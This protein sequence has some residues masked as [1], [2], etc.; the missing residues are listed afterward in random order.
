MTFIYNIKYIVYNYSIYMC[1][2]AIH[3]HMLGRGSVRTRYVY[4][5]VLC[6]NLTQAGVI[7]EKGAS[8]GK[9]PL[10][11]PAIRHFLGW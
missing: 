3:I 9:E 7:I 5:L 4:W 6:V 1:I 2:C 11:D 10:G 8:V